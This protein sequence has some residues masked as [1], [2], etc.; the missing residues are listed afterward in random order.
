MLIGPCEEVIDAPLGRLP[1]FKLVADTA[2][3]PRGWRPKERWCG[4]NLLGMFCQTK[5]TAGDRRVLGHFPEDRFQWMRE[6]GFN[7]ARLPLDY[8]FFVK[9][10][11]WMSPDESQLAKLDE[12]V[13]FGRRHGIHVQI[14]FHRAP[15]Y[16]CNP[17]QEPKSLFRDR[18]PLTAFTNLWSV[19]ARRY[20]GISNEELSFDLVNEPAPIGFYGATPSNYAVVARMALSAIRAVD[21]DRFVMSDGWR[22]GKE[23]VMELHPFDALSG[24]SMHCYEPHGLTHFGISNPKSKGPCPPWPPKG[25]TNGVEWLERNYV[26]AWRPAITDGT[27]LFVGELGVYQDSVPHATWLAWLEDVLT[28]C[29]RH[30]W[31][32]AL[33]NL[34]GVFGILDTPRTDYSFEDFHGHKLDRAALDVLLRHRGLNP[35]FVGS[36]V[37]FVR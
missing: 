17:P 28:L 15:G 4:F 31:G 6:W 29:D 10:G 20:R 35:R 12:A 19:L 13:R 11:D 16:C 8:R 32:W 21:A 7:F 3:A 27:S 33:W 2:E 23:P 5:M 14:N 36:S 22:W 26:K 1:Y 18:E 34:D 9:P 25:W 37:R 30:G 24:E